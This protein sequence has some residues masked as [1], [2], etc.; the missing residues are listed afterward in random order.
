MRPFAYRPRFYPSHRYFAGPTIRIDWRSGG[1]FGISTNDIDEAL[2]WVAE[3]KA[4]GL[5]VS[6]IPLK[7]TE[8]PLTSSPDAE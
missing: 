8:P 2:A 4:L 7:R 5:K 1:Y 3:A 6:H